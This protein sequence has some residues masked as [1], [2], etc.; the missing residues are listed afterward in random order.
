MKINYHLWPLY[1][2]Y[3][4]KIAHFDQLFDQNATGSAYILPENCPIHRIIKAR[5]NSFRMMYHE[6]W[7]ARRNL[8]STGNMVEIEPK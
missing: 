7:A 4:G 2:H 1:R 3:I 8:D 6:P 5:A